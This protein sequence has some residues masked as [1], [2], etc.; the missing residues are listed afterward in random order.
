MINSELRYAYSE[1]YSIKCEIACHSTRISSSIQTAAGKNPC[2]PPPMVK[3]RSCEFEIL[4]TL[5]K[6]HGNMNLGPSTSITKSVVSV[7]GSR[8]LE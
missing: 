6:C 8:S 5:M 1:N 7:G 2:M 4:T 3:A